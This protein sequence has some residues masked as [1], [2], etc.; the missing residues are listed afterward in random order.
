MNPRNKDFSLYGGRGISMFEP[1]INEFEPFISHMGPC[2]PG[3]TLERIDNDFGY[4]PWNCKW[5]SRKEQARNR[6]D[7]RRK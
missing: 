5:A 3:F 2:P 1:W 7:C 6:R 4:Y